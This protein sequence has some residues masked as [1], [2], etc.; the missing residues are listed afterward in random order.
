V[1]ERAAAGG[2]GRPTVC[3]VFELNRG[4]TQLRYTAP[5]WLPIDCQCL[6]YDAHEHVPIE[7]DSHVSQQKRNSL[8]SSD[9]NYGD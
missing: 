2:T 5:Y 7:E 4:R 1:I 6:G 8:G 9:T 3:V